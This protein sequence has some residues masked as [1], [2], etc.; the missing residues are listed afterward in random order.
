MGPSTGVCMGG[1]THGGWIWEGFVCGSSKNILVFESLR[2]V[3][4]ITSHHKYV[5][6][7]SG[8]RALPIC[9]RTGMMLLLKLWPGIIVAR[10]K[11]ASFKPA[12]C[13]VMWIAAVKLLR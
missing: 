3:L 9:S 13:V 10:R 6:L 4:V 2:T 5:Q 1:F 11:Y 7:C 8:N 12:N